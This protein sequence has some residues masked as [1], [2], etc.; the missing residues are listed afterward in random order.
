MQR[1]LGVRRSKVPPYHKTLMMVSLLWPGDV[2]VTLVAGLLGPAT[3]LHSHT[4]VLHK[5]RVWSRLLPAL[6]TSARYVELRS[7]TSVLHKQR[8]WSRLLPALLLSARYVELHSHTSVLHKQRFWSQLL[9]A[10]L[11][12]QVCWATLPHFSELHKQLVWSRLLPALLPSARYVEICCTLQCSTSSGSGYGCSLLS[13]LLP[14][15][16]S[17]TLTLQ[18][19]TNSGSGH[20]YSIL[21]EKHWAGFMWLESKLSFAQEAFF[22]WIYLTYQIESSWDSPKVV[23]NEGIYLAL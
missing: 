10:L 15:M 3:W 6:L 22:A 4:S 12:R 5:Q 13:S 2:A 8:V 1:N 20:G 14:G 9:L 23:W 21:E 19:S 17:F 11:I 18:C 7:H 16:F